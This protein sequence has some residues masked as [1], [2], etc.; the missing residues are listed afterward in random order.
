MVWMARV[1]VIRRAVRWAR[2]RLGQVLRSLRT[3]LMDRLMG[4]I[5]RNGIIYN[6][7]WEDPRVDGQLLSLG[8][9]DRLLVLTTGGCNVLDRLL[10]GPEHIVAVDLNPAQNALLELKL[11]AARALNHEQFFQLF[12]C[13]NRALFDDVYRKQLRPLLSQSAAAHWD[14][15]ASFFDGA[16][17][18]GAAGALAWALRSI[19]TVCGLGGLIAAIRTA[20]S[21]EAQRQLCDAYPREMARFARILQAGLPIICPFAGVPASQLELLTKAD[22]WMA[23]M[24]HRVFYGTFVAGDNYFWYGYLYGQYT[25]ECCPR[26]LRQEHFETLKVHADRVSIRTG[27]LHEVAEEFPDGYFTSMILLDHMD[28]LSE[29]QVLEEWATFCAKLDPAR[30]RVLWRSFADS[31]HLAPLAFLDFHQQDVAE[32]EG[33]HPDRVCTYNSTH[34]ATIPAGL[35]IGP[36]RVGP[37]SDAADTHA[38]EGGSIL[39]ETHMWPSTASATGSWHMKMYRLLPRLRGGV[40]V[41]LGGA[42]STRMSR[43][44]PSIS[45]FATVIVAVR[46]MED[47]ALV[48]DS[49]LRNRA[50]NLR[51]ALLSLNSTNIVDVEEDEFLKAHDFPKASVDMMTIAHGEDGLSDS[52]LFSAIQLASLLLR[53]GGL[54]VLSSVSPPSSERRAGLRD[55]LATCA[56]E[57]YVRSMPRQVRLLGGNQPEQL[58]WIGRRGK[59]LACE[60]KEARGSCDWTDAVYA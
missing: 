18:A 13:S 35:A 15:H 56:S 21:I 28:W 5:L 57:L 8:G 50:S 2:D 42:I 58:L 43:L 55:E 31:Q 36:G 48:R 34:L 23:K 26:Y 19:A 41:D 14:A 37:A 20:D 22:G 25:R 27:L 45:D 11:A 12:A 40:W 49:A 3:R 60:T 44:A 52:E 38:S 1:G 9:Q 17:H 10:D 51:A 7:A 39:I 6:V 24:L 54:L 4:I 47:L 30:G 33:R 53:P 16:M 59:P 32:A 29:A 46:H